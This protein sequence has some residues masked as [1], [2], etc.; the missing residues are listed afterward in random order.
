MKRICVFCASQLGWRI[1]YL[2]A[3]QNLG[4]GLARR[5][6]GLVY[7]GGTLGLMGAVADAALDAGGEV[8]GVVSRQFA[9]E[10]KVHKSLTRVYVASTTPERLG[11]MAELSDAFIV[12]PGGIGTLEEFWEVLTL[13][14]RAETRKPCGLLNVEGFYD[15]LLS[16]LDHATDEHLLPSHHS[17]LMVEKEPDQLLSNLCAECDPDRPL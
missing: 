10:E 17:M 14:Q 7:G 3:A 16:F 5:G 9:A 1:A 4:T 11:L 2:H 6:I 13:V 15:D 8:T 12:L